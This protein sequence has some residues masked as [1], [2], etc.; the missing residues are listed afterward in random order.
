MLTGVDGPRGAVL[1]PP[2]RRPTYIAETLDALLQPYPPVTRTDYGATCG[3]WTATAPADE[4]GSL[5]LAG[6][7]AA[8]DGLRALA[9]AAWAVHDRQG[10]LDP[11]QVARALDQLAAQG[12]TRITTS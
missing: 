10:D 6:H 2:H 7:G 12:L 4:N 3:G 9:A 8:I 11:N 5:A 1:A